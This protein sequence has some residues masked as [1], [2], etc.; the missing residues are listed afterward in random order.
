MKTVLTFALFVSAAALAGCG[1]KSPTAAEPSAA[2]AKPL[3]PGVWEAMNDK[4]RA[5]FMKNVVVPIMGAKFKAF[6]DAQKVA[7]GEEEFGE[8]TCKTCHGPGAEEGKFEMPSG[9][10]PELDF[11]N[12]DPADAAVNEFMAKEVKPVMANLLGLPEYSEA[13]PT[14]FGCLH[15]H[16]MAKAE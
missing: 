1:G 11:A 2:E 8:T 4:D 16:T 12:P 15:C 6:D 9:A 7:G 14:G 3:A 13:N 10:L 5:T